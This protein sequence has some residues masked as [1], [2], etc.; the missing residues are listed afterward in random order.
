MEGSRPVK[1]GKLEM[2]NPVTRISV[3]NLVE[4]ILQSGDLD[5]RRGT[6]DKD[7]ML[8]GSRLHRKLQKQMGGDYRAEVALLIQRYV[9]CGKF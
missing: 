4:F 8:K 9:C 5:N 2:D 7:A 6:I 1:G 3:R